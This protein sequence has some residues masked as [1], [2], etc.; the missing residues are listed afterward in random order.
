[1]SQL[2]LQT[3]HST[4]VDGACVV[5]GRCEG[6]AFKNSDNGDERDENSISEKLSAS[7]PTHA[8][9]LFYIFNL[10][11]FNQ[12]SPNEND[13]EFTRILVETMAAF[14]ET[15]NPSIDD[16]PWAKTTTSEYLDFNPFNPQM[17]MGFMEKN[18]QAWMFLDGI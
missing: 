2:A 5:V 12:F 4:M 14:V 8:Y 15:G 6:A 10:T 1:M 18:Y 16:I 11:V 7:E 13:V 17:K 3:Q 9:E